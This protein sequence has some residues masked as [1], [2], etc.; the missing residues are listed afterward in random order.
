A[1][2]FQNGTSIRTDRWHMMRYN[3]DSE[4]LY[5]MHNDPGETTNLANQSQYAE[6]LKG[7]RERLRERTD[8]FTERKT[9]R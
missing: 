8:H 7:L 6:V 4:E 3:D 5:D 9:Q 2:S 1:L